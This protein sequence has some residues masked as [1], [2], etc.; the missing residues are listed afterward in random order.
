[1]EER[2]PATLKRAEPRCTFR[3]PAGTSFQFSVLPLRTSPGSITQN[4]PFVFRSRH[5]HLPPYDNYYLKFRNVFKIIAFD[6]IDHHTFSN[7]DFETQE[8]NAFVGLLAQQ[9]S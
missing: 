8:N 7:E 3:S 1:M 5:G 4:A 2:W 9:T 6:E